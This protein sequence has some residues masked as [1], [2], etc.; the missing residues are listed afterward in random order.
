VTNGIIYI[1]D[2]GRLGCVRA[3]SMF[4]NHYRMGM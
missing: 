1:G 2:T 4:I 3:R